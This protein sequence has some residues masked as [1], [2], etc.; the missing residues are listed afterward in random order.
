LKTNRLATL[1]SI[2]KEKEK[3]VAFLSH[4]Q[5]VQIFARWVI[6]FHRQLFEKI[7][8]KPK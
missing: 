6:V 8:K 7:Q 3:N 5:G 2:S 4:S 1:V